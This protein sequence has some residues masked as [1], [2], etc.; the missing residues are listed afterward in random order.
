MAPRMRL[1]AAAS[2][3]GAVAVAGTV[4]WL[5]TQVYDASLVAI[6]HASRLDGIKKAHLSIMDDLDGGYGRLLAGEIGA[7]EYVA[8]ANA[9]SDRVRSLMSEASAASPQNEWRESY[10]AYV[11]ALQHYDAYIRGTVEV[12]SAMSG[13]G[14]QEFSSLASAMESAS[15]SKTAAVDRI[16]Q[17]DMAR[18]G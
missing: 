12:A 9:S 17:S 4:A 5:A 3:L 2:V 18:P 16:I 11:K 10:K 15:A 13:K 14:G 7:G 1:M 8:M 6:D